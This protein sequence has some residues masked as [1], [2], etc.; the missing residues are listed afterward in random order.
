MVFREYPCRRP[1]QNWFCW[2]FTGICWEIGSLGRGKTTLH[3]SPWF[4]MQ[5]HPENVSALNGNGTLSMSI[6]E[7][8]GMIDPDV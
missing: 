8:W 2:I 7:Y 1:M 3:G 4:S 5:T 6:H